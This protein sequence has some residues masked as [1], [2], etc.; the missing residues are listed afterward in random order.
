MRIEEQLLEGL[1]VARQHATRYTPDLNETLPRHQV[2]TPLRVAHFLAQVLHESSLMARVEENLNYSAQRLLEVFPRHFTEEQAR[3]YARKPALIASR[4]YRGRM[5]NGDEASGDGYRYRGRGLIQLTGKNNY[6]A[7]SEWSG[8]DVVAQPELV[9]DK[10]AVHSAVFYWDHR[11]LNALADSDDVRRVTRRINGG[12][13]GLSDRTAL[14][15]KAKELLGAS[16]GGLALEGTTHRV[17]AALLN[18][19]SQPRVVPST[20]IATLPQGTE[21]VVVPDADVAGWARVRVLLNGQIQG[22]YVARKYLKAIRLDRAQPASGETRLL[23]A[24]IPPVHLGENRRDITRSRAGG[25][26]YPLGETGRPRRSASRPGRKAGQLVKIVEYLDPENPQH[27]RYKKDGATYCNIYASDYCYLAGVYLPRVW[28]SPAALRAIENQRNVSVS[29]GDTVRELNANGLYDWLADFGH[30][31]GWRRETDLTV[32]QACANN[33]NVCI[34]VAQRGDLNRSGH[35]TAVVPEHETFS[36][37][38]NASN[39]VLRPLESQA[40][41]RNHRFRTAPSAWWTHS[42]YR[43][44]AFWRHA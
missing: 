6:R 13:A 33:G 25:R 18:L 27:G 12:Y 22:G 26:A 38:R 44:F 23:P 7:F 34:I 41:E 4:V 20:R 24:S 43:A 36:A 2:D 29:Y 8:E 30:A 14:L 1:G 19:R 15:D 40:G 39:D 31:F 11:D 10:Y 16:E 37:R 9:A 21:L 42:R 17:T 5:G 28:W 32:L 35:I 3:R